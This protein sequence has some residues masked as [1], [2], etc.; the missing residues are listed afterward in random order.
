[1]DPLKVQGNRDTRQR[2]LSKSTFAASPT[3]YGHALRWGVENQE[4]MKGG[5]RLQ[6][7][8]PVH[9]YFCTLSKTQH[10]QSLP[11]MA[12]DNELS[13]QMAVHTATRAIFATT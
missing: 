9:W 1:M 11:A 8:A 5:N 10:A 6:E 7:F 3:R 13:L 12:W 4:V 2:K